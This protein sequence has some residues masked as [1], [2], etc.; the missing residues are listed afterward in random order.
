ML[1]ATIVFWS[2]RKK[3]V[4]VPPGGRDF[5]RELFS[6]EGI[7]AVARLFTIY[8]FVSVFWALYD[9]TGSAWVLQ[10][11]RM[12]RTVFGVELLASQVQAI[13][14]ILIM[15]YIPLFAYVIYPFFNRFFALTPLKKISIGLFLAVPAFLISAWI[16]VLAGRGSGPHILWQFLAYM[17]I[18][19]AEIL[20]SITCLEF[21][22][23]QAPRKMKSFVMSM[24]MMSISI[25]NAFTSAV[26]YF[27]QG[28]DGRLLLSGAEYYLFFAGIM[29]VSAAGFVF[30][31]ARYR[32]KTYL[33][34]E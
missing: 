33:Q 23:T 9:Q 25:G 29:L 17:I 27:I 16:E 22:Y 31:A 1:A 21:S 3:F 20:I 12:D 26:N 4:H 7:S 34:G 8:I 32:E 11:Q 13:N 14:P 19:A 15:I 30:V 5:A 6:R 24:F 10:A 28:K 18:T 2:G